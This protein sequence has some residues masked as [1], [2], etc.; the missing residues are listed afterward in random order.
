M[1]NKGV[2]LIILSTSLALAGLGYFFYKKYV[3]FKPTK[4]SAK[5]NV[6]IDFQ[7]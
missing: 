3:P 4:K 7:P 5:F 6:Q 1:K 2:L